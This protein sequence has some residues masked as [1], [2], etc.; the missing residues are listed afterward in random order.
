MAPLS[1]WTQKKRHKVNVCCD[2]A[3]MFHRNVTHISQSFFG[4]A[5]CNGGGKF[6]LVYFD[7]TSS[8][9]ALGGVITKS[10]FEVFTAAKGRGLLDCDTL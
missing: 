10:R 1:L 7:M 4:V 9:K 3:L 6:F 8:R 2:A 5:R